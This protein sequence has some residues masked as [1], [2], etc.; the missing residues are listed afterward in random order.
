MSALLFLLPL[1]LLFSAAAVVVFL[2]AVRGGQLDDLDTPP[3][4]ILDDDEEPRGDSGEAGAPP[5]ARGRRRR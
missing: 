2:L 5:G 1:T 3:L 4:R